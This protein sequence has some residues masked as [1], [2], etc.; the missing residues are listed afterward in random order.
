MHNAHRPI[1]RNLKRSLEIY[2]QREAECA[3]RRV[4]RATFHKKVGKLLANVG[5]VHG[6]RSFADY[7]AREGLRNMVAFA[8]VSISSIFINQQL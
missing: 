7:S 8:I 6:Q 1:P 3:A 2:S 4:G 5:G